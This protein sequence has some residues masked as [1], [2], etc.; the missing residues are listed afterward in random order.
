MAEECILRLVEDDELSDLVEL[1]RTPE[2][3]NL[4]RFF[5][6]NL[7]RAKCLRSMHFSLIFPGIRERREA[8]AI[9]QV[10]NEYSLGDGMWDA[11]HFTPKFYDAV[12]RRMM[13][14]GKEKLIDDLV[15]DAREHL[16]RLTAE[17]PQFGTWL[18]ALE[19]SAA[20]ALWSA[21][22]S[23]AS[24][25]WVY[26]VNSRPN[27]FAA[28]VM[29][30]F[31]ESLQ[32]QRLSSRS[33]PIGIAAKYSFDL[34]NHIGDIVADG[35]DFTSMS[36]VKKAYTSAFELDKKEQEI[37]EAQELKR[38]VLI[39]NLIAHRSGVVDAEFKER[40]GCSDNVGDELKI[41][42]GLEKQLMAA[43]ESAGVYLLKMVDSSL[44]KS[45]SA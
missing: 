17:D 30:Q 43:V 36:D 16:D 34:R 26:A 11:G 6:R 22:E 33:I 9:T 42:D 1:L 8:E 28:R 14:G 29:K 12:H 23:L 20:M 35:I 32:R 38:L 25:L 7:A 31:S 2:V 3:Q 27:L 39:R 21:F 37:L 13:Q 40:T 18:R 45:S 10:L 44:A 15:R 24:D 19:Q 5:A 4:A 41:D